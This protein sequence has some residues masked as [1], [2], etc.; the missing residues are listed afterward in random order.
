[1]IFCLF[2]DNY[3]GLISLAYAFMMLSISSMGFPS[4]FVFRRWDFMP[5]II[6]LQPDEESLRALCR[7]YVISL[8]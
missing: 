2:S 1:M 6:G 5:L 7:H 4:V 3:V 8:V